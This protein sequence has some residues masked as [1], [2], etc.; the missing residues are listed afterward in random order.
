MSSLGRRGQQRTSVLDPQQQVLAC[1]AQ[2]S[3]SRWAGWGRWP[4]GSA[5]EPRP[6]LKVVLRPPLLPGGAGEESGSV[7]AWV[8]G[9]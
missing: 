7:R 3:G 1:Q 6:R 4:P 9:G 5:E 2:A 8:R